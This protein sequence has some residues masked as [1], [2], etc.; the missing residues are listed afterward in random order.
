MCMPNDD[1]N[2]IF[3]NFF[4]INRNKI[5]VYDINKYLEGML[6]SLTDKVL[7]VLIF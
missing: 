6:T 7:V 2:G 5:Y 3:W 4:G 1:R